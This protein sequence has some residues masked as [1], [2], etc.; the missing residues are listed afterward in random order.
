MAENYL[1]DDT[2]NTNKEDEEDPILVAQRYL[3]I[4]HQI[5]IF[6]ATRKAE[7][8]QSL[9]AM[10]EKIKELMAAIPGGRVLL[11]H[12]K[13]IE[14]TRGINSGSTSELIA[15]NIEEEKKSIDNVQQHPTNSGGGT[16]TLSTDFA[17]SLAKS[18][19]TALQNNNVA[20]NGSMNELA[21]VLNK[22]FNA[23][24]SNMQN[25][26]NTIMRQNTM[27][28]SIPV[29]SNGNTAAAPVAAQ[30]NLQNNNST[31][32]NNINI[33]SS[34]FDSI[35]RTLMQ[36]DERRHEDMMQ[37]V[38]AI[39]KNIVASGF[40]PL[41]ATAI[42]NSVSSD[43]PATA[44]ANSVTEALRQN[45]S[46]Q[47]EAIKAF[48]EMLVQAIT[49]SQQE[50]AQTIAQSTPRHTVKVVVSQ[51]VDIDDQTGS[52][53]VNKSSL[54]QTNKE[55]K[56]TSPAKNNLNKD[57]SNFMKSFSDKINETTNKI[58]KNFETKT[59]EN[60]QNKQSGSDTL[61]N[62]INK[63]LNKINEIKKQTEKSFSDLKNDIKE[64]AQPKP[65]IKSEPKLQNQPK[66][67]IKNEPKPEPKNEPK[68]QNQPKPEI[69]NEPKPQKQPKPEIKNEPKPQ[70][71]PKPEIK[72]EPKPQ[73][74]Q[75]P[76][77]KDE[78]KQQLL[79][80]DQVLSNIIPAAET[81]NKNNDNL[82]I[83]DILASI[84]TENDETNNTHEVPDIFAD[85][86]F[87]AP[88]T[89]VSDLNKTDISKDSDDVLDLADLELNTPKAPE[90]AD[91]QQNTSLQE[92]AYK[93]SQL[94]SY[95]DA[96]L[97]IKNALN[98]DSSDN[99]V[100]LNNLDVQP[101]SLSGDDLLAKTEVEKT[102]PQNIFSEQPQKLADFDDNDSEWE[103]V[104]ENGNPVS[105]DNGEW[106]YVDENGN[107][108]S[109]DD[110]EWEYVDENGN[111]V[112]DNDGEWE[113]VDENGN[114]VSGN[115][116]EW[117]YVDE[118]GNPV[119]DDDEWEYV[120]ENGNPIDDTKKS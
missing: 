55:T 35:N 16:L 19:A 112:S 32:V 116:G 63:S 61:L 34:Y 106:E 69:K 51:D 43:V 37:I 67:E 98:S 103:Y 72:S 65:E 85:N 93:K 47:M 86:S 54:P 58:A 78:S 114:P 68:P 5:H 31:T 4:F 30:Q 75:K 2:E 81:S 46:Q 89:D 80:E 87:S 9:L 7:F 24:A 110:S 53:V 29:T 28:T 22:S 82:S 26:T 11:E 10:P 79:T 45:N 49:Q 105:G 64:K 113:Y 39:N 102:Q 52:T 118:N 48:G 27:Q 57:N 62:R 14:E 3:N 119:S 88:Q 92:P 74:Q 71:Q 13:E 111:P 101:V 83:D 94:H 20:A 18:L 38:S 99:N 44:I 120:D 12:I 60:N 33:D 100:S 108:V 1:I 21:A 50:L 66:P 95:E 91:K 115:D 17:D 59:A 107:P 73:N 8:D 6:N 36:N 77:P 15:Q 90:S 109:G 41:A 23:Y 56:N 97:K 96:L 25:L 84:P 40:S 76:E 42:N 104:D 70:N 117:E